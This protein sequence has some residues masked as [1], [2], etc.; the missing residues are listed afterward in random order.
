[1]H[2]FTSVNIIFKDL[3]VG[4]W[5]HKVSI[6]FQGVLFRNLCHNTDSTWYLFI[7]NCGSTFLLQKRRF[8]RIKNREQGQFMWV[9]GGVD[10]MKSGRVVVSAQVEPMTDI[11]FYQ[12]GLIK[13]KVTRLFKRCSFSTMIIIL[14]PIPWPWVVCVCLCCSW[15]QPW[16]FRWWVTLSQQ[17]RQFCGQKLAIPSRRGPP[18]WKAWSAALRSPAWFWMSKVSNQVSWRSPSRLCQSQ[19]PCKFI[20]FCSSGG[21]T[22][23]KDHVVIMP[24]DEER[25]S[26]QWD[27]ELL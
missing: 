15:S 22:Y 25:P 3:E 10:E 17:P 27:I 8:F 11:W 14:G 7:K 26:Q 9:Q 21:K 23:D 5:F 1:M 2:L 12:D 4:L 19:Q 13:N 16:A 20:I 18:R 24:E 6:L